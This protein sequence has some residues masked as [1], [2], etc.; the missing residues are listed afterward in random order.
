MQISHTRI[1]FSH[2]AKQIQIKSKTK[3]NVPMKVGK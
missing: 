1:K 3:V 2:R